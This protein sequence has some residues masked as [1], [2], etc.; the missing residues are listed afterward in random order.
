MLGIDDEEVKSNDAME[1]SDL[2]HGDET[3]TCDNSKEEE[4]RIMPNTDHKPLKAVMRR[5]NSATILPSQSNGGAHH[6]SVIYSTNATSEYAK[7]QRLEKERHQQ[8]ENM[9]RQ[10]ELLEQKNLESIKQRRKLTADLESKMRE[11]KFYEKQVIELTNENQH[12]KAQLESTIRVS[13][14][15]VGI[16]TGVV[17]TLS[18]TRRGVEN[19]PSLGNKLAAVGLAGKDALAVQELR[20][21]REKLAAMET[22][23]K[24]FK[25][26]NN[27]LSMQVKIL[28]DALNFRSEEIGLSGHADLL[29]KVAKLKGEVTALKNELTNKVDELS[30]VK[31]TK[32]ALNHE[33][34]DLQGQIE[35]IQQRLAQSQQESY[36]LANSDV[37]Q[38]LRSAEQERD[39]LIEYIQSDMQKSTT[40]AKQV[41]TLEGELRILRKKASGLEEKL[42]ARDAACKDL[43]TQLQNVDKEYQ[44]LRDQLNQLQRSFEQVRIDRDSFQHQLDRKILEEEELIKAQVTLFSQV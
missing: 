1:L 3:D 20:A 5:S 40:L 29:T 21:C 26:Q 4:S 38:L 2:H 43:Q 34:Q 19:N 31:E 8:L 14:G 28:Q 22:E 41:E 24:T 16:N 30:S 7:Q 18:G 11:S 42:C 35:L 17:G 10:M 25:I 37:G 44:I 36:R 33:K 39:L 6:N 27:E 32:E 12:L 23:N 9:Q 13:S 15:V